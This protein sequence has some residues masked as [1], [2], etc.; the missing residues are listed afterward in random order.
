M[1]KLL[2]CVLLLAGCSKDKNITNPTSQIPVLTTAAVTNIAD[3]SATCGGTVSSDGGFAITARGICWST[4][5][6]PTINNSKTTDGSGKGS[7]TS[8][9]TSLHRNTK[10][11]V[12]AYATN[13]AGTGY[14]D[15]VSFTTL[16]AYTPLLTTSTATNI[17][18]STAT[19][20]GT[21]NSD[22]GYTVAARGV[23]WS[24]GPNPSIS[25]SKT[26]DG[27]GTGSFSSALKGLYPNT[28]Y[29][30]R[31]YATNS[32][33][34]GYGNTVS[35]TTLQAQIPQV[36]TAGVTN[37]TMITASC[38]GTITSDG[39]AAVTARGICWSTGANPTINDSKTTDGAGTGI[40]TSTITGLIP[41][42]P[43]YVRAYATNSAGTG[44][45]NEVSFTTSKFTMDMILI[46][47]GTF[48]M[49]NITHHPN[50]SS[51]EEPVHP[52]T[53]SYSF[54]I[55]RT[56]VTQAQWKAVMGSNPSYGKGDS[57]PVEQ[58][59][60]YDAAD[61]CNRL[62]TS[63]GLAPCY[64]GSGGNISCDFTANGYR[65]PTEAE[66]EYACRGGSNSD[67]TD[68]Y[69][70][71]MTNPTNDPVLDIAGWYTGNSGNKTHN[72]GLK[73]P[74]SLG[75]LDMSGNVSEWC[76]DWY[77]DVYYAS[78]PVTDPRGPATGVNRVIRGG[79]WNYPSVVCRSAYRGR[80]DP[81]LKYSSTG[82]RVVRNN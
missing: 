78:S 53:T 49:G 28:P 71:N 16:Q 19:C 62:S 20:G 81:N 52:V 56:E 13:N 43:Y 50:G 70:G 59:S 57:L 74:N 39:G 21:I 22:G 18:I 25:D 51:V 24:T 75:L 26:T 67:T 41:K 68:F 77:L 1:K 31:A 3:T 35:F 72:T 36:T 64:T 42:T 6:T 69:T 14:G 60:W 2:V 5:P 80:I 47:A 82:F 38:G 79:S 48:R 34:T 9:L 40:F 76:W 44:Y 7:F 29:Y 46:P 10:Y 30:V 33:G 58:M 73:Q 61:Y 63:E 17:S 8:A 66:W 23:C 12:R 11:Y 15:T 37:I 55:G 65:L 27:A 45:G 32:A 4:E 54:L